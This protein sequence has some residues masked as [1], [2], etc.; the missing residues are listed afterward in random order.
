MK[1]GFAG[2]LDKEGIV[3]FRL[4]LMDR[5]V[6]LGE[7]AVAL[8]CVEAVRLEQPAPDLLVVIGGDGTLLRFASVCAERDIP[9]LGVNLGRIGFFP[10]ELVEAARI[11]GAG[12]MRFFKDIL[13]PLSATSIA[14]WTRTSRPCCGLRRCGTSL[15]RAMN[16]ARIT[17]SAARS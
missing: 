13:L 8:D 2:N 12:P 17:C 16:A 1:I 7:S 10:D 6:A 9:I 15:W 14:A 11:D 4:R 3:E 5:A